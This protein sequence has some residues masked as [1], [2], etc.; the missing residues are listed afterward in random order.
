MELIIFKSYLSLQ[1]ISYYMQPKRTFYYF[2]HWTNLNVGYPVLFKSLHV[3]KHPL[4]IHNTNHR[5][6]QIFIS[7]QLTVNSVFSVVVLPSGLNSFLCG[8]RY[9]LQNRQGLFKNITRSNKYCSV[10]PIYTIEKM[11]T[12]QNKKGNHNIN[13]FFSPF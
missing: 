8:L 13:I 5:W 1:T 10:H 4:T 12:T 11:F 2:S 3:T 9:F 7:R 6:T